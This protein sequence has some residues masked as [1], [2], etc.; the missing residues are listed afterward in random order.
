M[1][2]ILPHTAKRVRHVE[3]VLLTTL[4]RWGYQEIIPP[5]FEYLDVLQTGLEPDLIE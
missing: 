5:T 4:G 1:A 3:E 2:T